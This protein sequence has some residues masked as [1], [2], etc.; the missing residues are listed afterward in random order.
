[1]SICIVFIFLLYLGEIGT[2]H[3]LDFVFESL[4]SVKFF[5]GYVIDF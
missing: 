3:L 5:I 2:E 1:M 4:F